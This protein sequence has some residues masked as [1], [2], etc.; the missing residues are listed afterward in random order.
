VYQ[1]TDT[2]L[3]RQVAIKVLPASV[4]GDA[5]RL[6]RFQREAE[7][8]AALNHPNIAAIYGLE[9]TAACTALVMELVEGEDL[10]AHVARGPIALA[11]ALPIARQIAEALEA[12][13]EQG[14]IHRDLKPANIKV[15]PDGTVKVLDFGLA[16]AQEPASAMSPG[17]S[18]SPTITTPAMTQAGMILG[19]AA[20]MSPEQAKGR[21]ADKRSDIWAFGC[22]LYEML[23]GMRPFDGED[24]G[25]TLANVLKI[26]PDWSAVPPEIA[27]AIRTLLQSCLTKDRRRRVADISTA[28]FVLEKGSSL[29]PPA[30]RVS[31]AP[32]SPRPLWRRVVTSAAWLIA[33]LIVSGAGVWFAMRPV[34]S[35]VSRLLIAPSGATAISINGIDR[36]LAISP[37]GSHIVYVGDNRSQL[38]VRVLDALEPVA[39]YKGSIRGPFVS[40]DGQWVGFA[41]G[42]SSEL[43]RVAM[44]GGPAVTIARLDGSARGAVWAPDDTILFATSATT[45]LQRVAVGGTPE[46]LTRPDRGQGKAD[47]LWPEMLPGGRAVLFTITAQSGG[48][49][50]A[51]VAVLDLQSGTRKVLVSGGSDA[52]YVSSGH[53]VYAATGSLRAVG[54]DLSRLETRGT[55]VP[56]V[57]QVVTSGSGAADAAVANNGTL[58]YVSGTA[59]QRT[60]VWVDRQGLET[61]IPAPPRAYVY[62]R[63][64]PDG[65][66][67][68]LTVLDQENDIWLWD[69]T[70]TTLTRLTFDGAGDY[71]QAWMPDGLRL[72]FS[73]ERAGARNLFRQ[74][75][76]GT[77]SVERLTESPNTQNVASVTP[78]GT[79]LIFHEESPISG[80]D[81]M[82][83]ALD[84]TRRVTPL[85]QTPFNERNGFVSP[86]GRWLAYEANESGQYEIHVRPY[87]EVNTGHW[88]VS[89][90]GG[91]RPLWAQ[92]GRELFYLTLSGGMMRVGVQP[93]QTWTATPST[94]LLIKEGYFTV[95][96]G[97]PGRTYDLSPDGQRF[98]MI[99][100]GGGSDQTATP[101]SLIVVQHWFEEL[102]RLVPTK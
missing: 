2:N 40:P 102:K 25:D 63:L 101:S 26:D 30:G 88:Q 4:A 66:R 13:H 99:K 58:V 73:S 48:L 9:K 36:D 27:P 7:V 6:V 62:P 57:P 78:D 92:S 87:P 56:V 43:R 55:P 21:P 100:Q 29:A 67:L 16:K 70:R 74:A 28:L 59:G 95:P 91:T 23:T 33:G 45:G 19:T 1:A 32:L 53:L 42:E 41:D 98:L 89:T 71:Q 15:R 10:S 60:L 65:T 97:N 75:A 52:H 86:D 96:A 24:V 79:R 35:R 69:P 84:G 11:D 77:G 5:D 20:Y 46:V 34:P 3:K 39:I 81:L 85:V 22:V 90:A 31:T 47:H 37:D 49:D 61:P 14:I 50:E 83:V 94:R 12:A 68:A 72:I 38:F 17:A 64:A 8:L 82:Q 76:D 54:F 93:G 80:Y 18:Q 44:S 51:K